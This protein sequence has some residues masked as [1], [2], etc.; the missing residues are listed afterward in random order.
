MLTI[1]NYYGVER[2]TVTFNPFPCIPHLHQQQPQW[3]GT[4]PVPRNRPPSH[5]HYVRGL[6]HPTPAPTWDGHKAVWGDA[7]THAAKVC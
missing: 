6:C 2:G 5:Y 4:L 3:T 1:V 7:S